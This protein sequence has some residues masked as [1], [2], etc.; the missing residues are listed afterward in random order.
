LGIQAGQ[1]GE[2]DDR[3][4]A[5]SLPNIGGH[6]ESPEI[7]RVS[8]EIDNRNSERPEHRN[9]DAEIGREHHANDSGQDDPGNEVGKV[10]DGLH[11][12]LEQ[13]VADFVQKERQNNR[14]RKAE[15][16]L[17]Q[18]DDDGVAE[19]LRTRHAGEEFLEE[20]QSDESAVEDALDEALAYL[21]L[22]VDEGDGYARDRSIA[23]HDQIDE[24][25]KHHQQEGAML[26]DPRPKTFLT[27]T[28]C[29]CHRSPPLS[30]MV[31]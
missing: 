15:H 1:S 10:G 30:V 22:E 8:K 3:S 19:D 27:N 26:D 31:V 16:Y 12:P 25:G 17:V 20:L 24:R 28:Y 14:R 4:P 23:E 13:G 11:H 9:D 7:A 29:S 21:C 18:A 2:V 6:Q 5:Y